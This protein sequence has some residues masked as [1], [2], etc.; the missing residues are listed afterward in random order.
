MIILKSQEEVEKLRSANAIVVEVQALME[1]LIAPGVTTGE[2]DRLAEEHVRKRGGVPSFLGYQGFAHTLCTAHNDV[3]V[4]GIPNATPLEDGD[5]IGIDCGVY[6][7]GFHG[8]HAKTY[9]VGN[10]QPDVAHDLLRVT[11]EAMYKG[12]EQ[13]QPGNRL[14][15][16]SAAIQTHVESQGFSIVRDY[17]GHGVGRDLHEEPQIPNFGKAGTGL[18]LMPGLVVAIEPMVNVGTAKVKLMDDGWTVKTRD[19][20]LSAHFEHS[21]VL[22]ESGPEILSKV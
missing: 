17:V 9:C 4:H 5:I 20:S 18:K 8:D 3:V 7:D 10:K 12:I 14:F 15:D 1:E 19:G 2:L 13:L 21:V 16:I 11:E 22:T 6:L